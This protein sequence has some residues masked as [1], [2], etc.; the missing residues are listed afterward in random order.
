[1]T[2]KDILLFQL[3]EMRNEFADALTDLTHE[4]MVDDPLGGRNPIGWIVCHCI[5][6]FDFFL[7]QRQLDRSVTDADEELK[8]FARYGWDPPTEENPPPDLTRVPDAFDRV[9]EI[10]IEV[11][12]SLDEEALTNLAPYWH[13]GRVESTAGNCVRVIN[14]SNAHL[15]QIWMIRGAL[16][17]KDHWPVQTLYK[18]PN[19]ERGRFYVPDRKVILAD[20]KR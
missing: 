6:N 11:I 20:R 5:N 9:C 12:D 15:R 18:K 3:E 17:D 16:G 19:E 13:H 10:C 1:M 14:H 4:Q 7:H 8:S 2:R